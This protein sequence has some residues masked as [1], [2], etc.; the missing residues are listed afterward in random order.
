MHLLDIKGFGNEEGTAEMVV[1]WK[2][3]EKLYF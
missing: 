3:E 2:K 1:L